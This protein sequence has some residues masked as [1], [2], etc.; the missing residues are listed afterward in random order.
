MSEIECVISSI[1][2]D[3]DY[4]EIESVEAKCKRCGHITQAYGTSSESI[5]RC[6]AS[7]HEECPKHESNFYIEEWFKTKLSE[8]QY[9]EKTLKNKPN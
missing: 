7:M 2:L 6:L 9:Y 5:K 4:T 3:G 1:N 8:I